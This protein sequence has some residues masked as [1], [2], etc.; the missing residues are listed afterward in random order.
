[1]PHWNACWGFLCLYIHIILYKR[2]QNVGLL[3]VRKVHGVE[4]I[5]NMCGSKLH[6]VAVGLMGV[7]AVYRG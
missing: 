5:E 3:G 7:H 2:V 1:M 4:E 6:R